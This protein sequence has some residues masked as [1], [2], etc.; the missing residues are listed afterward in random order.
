M[1]T[2]YLIQNRSGG[3]YLAATNLPLDH[4]LKQHNGL[5]EIKPLGYI[6]EWSYTCYITGFNTTDFIFF[7]MSWRNINI[8]GMIDSIVGNTVQ[9]RLINLVILLN[10]LVTTDSL[11]LHLCTRESVVF[12]ADVSQ[13]SSWNFLSV[14]DESPPIPDGLY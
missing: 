7:Q 9:T 3:T 1:S 5:N 8:H 13:G 6:D 10:T 11:T 14:I 4:R 12:W 2:V